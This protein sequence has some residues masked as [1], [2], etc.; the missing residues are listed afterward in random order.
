[1][2]QLV[3][4]FKSDNILF[5]VAKDANSKTR[6]LIDFSLA[7]AKEFAALNP[8]CDIHIRLANSY[9]MFKLSFNDRRKNSIEYG[10]DCFDTLDKLDQWM[11]NLQIIADKKYAATIV[12]CFNEY[13]DEDGS[14]KDGMAI[15]YL[16]SA[17]KI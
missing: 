5:Q 6:L 12:K 7:K 15:S 9:P 14:V 11:E 13:Y 2:V 3:Q 16:Q 8:Q 17:L 1:M 10:V 4:H